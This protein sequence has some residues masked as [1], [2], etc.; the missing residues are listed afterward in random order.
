MLTNFGRY[1]LACLFILIA[2]TII[3]GLLGEP[4]K[5]VT[6]EVEVVKV[7]VLTTEEMITKQHHLWWHFTNKEK[8]AQYVLVQFCSPEHLPSGKKKV[9]VGWSRSHNRLLEAYIANCQKT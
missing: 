4:T 8:D 6:K 1:A 7:R 3:V 2:L 5:R 9:Y